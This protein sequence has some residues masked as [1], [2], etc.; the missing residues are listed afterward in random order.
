MT[1]LIVALFCLFIG[2]FIAISIA[3]FV[4]GS[5][6]N[7]MYQIGDSE[8][9][10]NDFSKHSLHIVRKEKKKYFNFK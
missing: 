2:I 8:G 4:V 7:K 10:Y 1:K 3:I 5:I 6:L 9:G